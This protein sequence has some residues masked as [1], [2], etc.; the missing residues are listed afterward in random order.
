MKISLIKRHPIWVCLLTMW[1]GSLSCNLLS[2][3]P[4]KQLTVVPLF[5]ATK[6]ASTQQIA[7]PI[8]EFLPSPTLTAAPTRPAQP[9][10]AASYCILEDCSQYTYPGDWSNGVYGGTEGVMLA[11][12]GQ[13]WI[14]SNSVGIQQWDLQTGKL[15][16]TIPNTVEN[17]FTDIKYDGRQVWAYALVS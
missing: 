1:M 13:I 3:F 8:Q 14:A 9:V 10:V 2:S 17:D 4:S 11:I 6:P 12:P 5:P 15:V 16:K 7:T